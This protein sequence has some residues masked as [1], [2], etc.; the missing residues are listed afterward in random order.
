MP[1]T[2][3][4]KR[5]ENMDIEFQ[6]FTIWLPHPQGESPRWTRCTLVLMDA[7]NRLVK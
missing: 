7:I 5:T 2:M 1:K 3:G 6:A 4:L